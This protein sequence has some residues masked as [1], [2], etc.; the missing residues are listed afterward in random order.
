MPCVQAPNGQPPK[1]STGG[2]FNKK[3]DCQS[4][5]KCCTGG[6][7]C[8]EGT[9]DT[10]IG[11]DLNPPGLECFINLGYACCPDGKVLVIDNTVFPEFRKCCSPGNPPTNCVDPT[12]KA[13]KTYSKV[14]NGNPVFDATPTCSDNPCGLFSYGCL[15]NCVNGSYELS[16]AGPCDEGPCG[17]PPPGPC[18]ENTSVNINCTW[19]GD[20]GPNG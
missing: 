2:P 1:N 13:C 18:E 3:S 6:D 7:C 17:P 15:Y 11:L 5:C 9:Y 4:S 14:V 19:S 8:P 10:G 12:I 16:V 20:G